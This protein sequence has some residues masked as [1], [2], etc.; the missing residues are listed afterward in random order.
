MASTTC[1]PGTVAVLAVDDEVS[2][3]GQPPA[4]ADRRRSLGWVPAIM[5]T[6]ALALFAIALANNA[7]RDGHDGWSGVV[8]WL[9]LVAIVAPTSVRVMLPIN[10]SER[11]GLIAGLAAVLYLVKVVYEPAQFTLHDEL[12]QYRTTSQIMQSGHLFALNP[13]VRADPYFPG[14]NVATAVLARVTHLSIF[15]SGVV[16]IGVARLAGVL[17]LFL[18]FERITKSDR[19]A[20][21]AV[22]VY[23]G[24]PNFLYFDAQYGYESLALPLALVAL[25]AVSLATRGG[26]GDVWPACIFAVIIIIAVV[27]THHI[28]A[29]WLV[30]V[31]LVWTAVLMLRRRWSALSVTA[32]V[33]AVPAAVGLLAVLVWQLGVAR[34]ATLPEVDPIAHGITA[35][36]RTLSG[37]SSSGKTLFQSGT[38]QGGDPLWAQVVG[39]ASVAL[40]LIVLP[41]GWWIVIRTRHP[42]HPLGVIL[43]VAT[44]LYPA[45]LALRLTQSGTETSNRA[46][47][48]LYIG[49]GLLAAVVSVSARRR[50][51]RH[52]TVAARHRLSAVEIR[53]RYGFAFLVSAYVCVLFIGG[54][55]VGWAP[56]ERQP[57]PYLA[58]AESRSV[59]PLSV[60]AALWA[61]A[62]LR[63]GAYI[64]TDST[65]GL[66]MSAYAKLNPQ[67]GSISGLP[68]SSLFYSTTYGPEQQRIV[69]GD[70]IAYVVVDRRISTSPPM[71][72][73]YFVDG[74]P[75]GINPAAPLPAADLTKFDQV[76][77]FA[78]VYDSGPIAIYATGLA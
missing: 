64:A 68:V 74:V 9:A 67:T 18:L 37:T 44:V 7:A 63:P 55:V 16:L 33:P 48:Y 31:L 30:A 42:R 2:R 11:L 8:F 62:H 54:F 6:S 4:P 3:V 10:R 26:D 21:V 59:D 13:I 47:E 20:A 76:P 39:F 28:A 24:N 14:M 17:A 56:Y 36:V 57:G 52:E 75:D 71:S 65:N 78:K 51:V 19:L 46:S 77:G 5:L 70:K 29:Y 25:L 43:A 58:A 22:L 66:L 27:I 45:T 41:F 61:K 53:G 34:S 72:S 35:L 60:R 69:I 73:G 40:S 23:V 1:R 15:D 50:L 49:V 32:G 38:G 12:G